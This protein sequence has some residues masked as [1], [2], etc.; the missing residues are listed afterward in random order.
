MYVRQS[1]L[2]VSVAIIMYIVFFALSPPEFV[3][4][5]LSSPI[6]M[7]ASFG[8]AVYIALYH[9]KAIGG[10]L[11]VA[12]LA[13][14]TQVTEHMNAGSDKVKPE[15]LGSPKCPPATPDYDGPGQVCFN[16][17][18]NKVPPAPHQGCPT[19][20]TMSVNGQCLK[21]PTGYVLEDYKAGDSEQM[22]KKTSSNS[23]STT[24]SSSVDRPKN[25]GSR[26]SDPPADTKKETTVPKPTMS[27]NL[28]N[29]AS[30]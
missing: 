3:R 10:L 12:L 8:L 28:E 27:C 25:G 26:R 23:E 24:T 19:G 22:C 2:F 21:C 9:S 16:R 1:D 14:M 29:F 13:S 18:D 15:R 11:I 5:I 30:Y 20:G 6:G 4:T 17:A 7:S